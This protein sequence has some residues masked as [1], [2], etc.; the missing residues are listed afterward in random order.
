[1]PAAS[2]DKL[3]QRLSQGKPPSAILLEGSDHY[4]RDMCRNKLIEALVPEAARDWA[5]ARLPARDSGWD[6]ILGQAEMM[7]MLAAHKV[8]VVEGAES[9]EK[10][11]EKS[12]DAILTAI[13]KYLESPAPFTTLIIEA[14]SLD[15]RQK[16]AKLL[17]QHARVLVVEL[18][19]SPE[20]AVLLA[21]QMAKDL[22]AEIDRDAAVLL[23]DIM[24]GEPA[25]IR[26]EMEKLATYVQGRER[27]AVA[28]VETL[29]VAARKNTIW[30][31][32]DILANRQRGAALAFL[33]NLLRE[34]EQPAALVGALAFRYRQLIEGRN[35]PMTTGGYAAYPH[36]N[37]AA[38]AADR[39][40]HP[41]SKKELLAGLAALAEADSQFKSSNPNP[42]ATMEFLIARLTAHAS[43][44]PQS[45]GSN[46][47]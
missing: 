19:I 40:P 24:N 25:R 45:S 44:P 12:R 4:L 46:R 39:N 31:L 23:A 1:M 13:E 36:Q 17:H 16:F 9:V 2:P 7:P 33:N 6:E 22:G 10:L 20:S 42:R 11:G 28:D 38:G 34:G 3:L 8:I 37:L 26:I 43:A 35:F 32:A 18:T 21:V 47:R 27:I 41:A 29:V 5:V 15:G 30:Q 14:A